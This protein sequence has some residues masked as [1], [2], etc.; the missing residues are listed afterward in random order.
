MRYTLFLPSSLFPLPCSFREESPT[1]SVPAPKSLKPRDLY[2]M[3]IRI[4]IYV[5]FDNYQVIL[6]CQE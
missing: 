6:T 1:A 3:G 4:A 5:V 2:L